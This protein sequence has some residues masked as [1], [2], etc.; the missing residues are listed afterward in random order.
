ME[1]PYTPSEHSISGAEAAQSRY[2][3]A[4][5]GKR[6]LNYLVDQIGIMGLGFL[7][8]LLLAVSLEEETLNG[9]LD[10]ALLQFGMGYILSFVYYVAVEASTGRT[11]GKLVT[12]TKVLTWR[13]GI[14]TF[15]Q[16]LG[17]SLA[18]W[19]PFEPFSALTSS[20]LMW[21]DDW[22]GTITV[23]LRA[24]QLPPLRTYVPGERPTIIAHSIPPK[25]LI[26]KASDK[27]SD[28]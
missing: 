7:F 27:P 20:G 13:Y 26:P 6:L 9:Y 1:N 28:K 15:G 2:P 22:S 10:S 25:P 21:H 12:G 5:T 19:V 14:P 8:G 11:L 16:I 18:R 3:L 4:G 24:K 23:D 17:R